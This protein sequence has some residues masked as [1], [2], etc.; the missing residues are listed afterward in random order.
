MT[1]QQRLEY[2]KISKQSPIS[3]NTGYI[4]FNIFEFEQ[5]DFSF[6]VDVLLNTGITPDKGPRL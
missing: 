1:E 5:A 4:Q 2:L 6:Y 3:K